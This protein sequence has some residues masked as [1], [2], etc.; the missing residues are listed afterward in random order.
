[1][2]TPTEYPTPTQVEAAAKA[3]YEC[4]WSPDKWIDCHPGTRVLCLKEAEAGLRAARAEPTTASL[5]AALEPAGAQP[6]IWRCFHCSEVFTSKDAAADHFG[7]A[8]G[9]PPACVVMLTETEKAIVEDRREWK[10]RAQRAETAAETLGLRLARV[11]ADIQKRWKDARTVE[12]VIR[13]HDESGGRALV[14]EDQAGSDKAPLLEDVRLLRGALAL[15][16]GV[17]EADFG[18]PAKQDRDDEP[19]GLFSDGKMALTFGHLRRAR[20]ALDKVS[21]AAEEPRPETDKV[22]S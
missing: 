13:L 1:M 6:T 19:V 21:D 15:L 2:A 11:E 9:E 17:N 22:M 10:Q 18:R 14:T 5:G 3:I 12:D 4:R 8:E 7:A 16:L 20:D